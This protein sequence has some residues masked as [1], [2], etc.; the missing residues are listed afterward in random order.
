M[1]IFST[2][3]VFKN[4][5]DEVFILDTTNEYAPVLMHVIFEFAPTILNFIKNYEVDE[6]TLGDYTDY[7]F[8]FR[9]KKHMN[10]G[11]EHNMACLVKTNFSEFQKCVVFN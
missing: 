5:D 1:N 11:S 9:F 6:V 10:I 4:K 7:L 3:I 2:S 8:E